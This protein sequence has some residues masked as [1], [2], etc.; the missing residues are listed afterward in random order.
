MLAQH[1]QTDEVIPMLA[2]IGLGLALVS[3]IAGFTPQ[4]G[5]SAQSVA[6]I[7]SL[8]GK[9]QV[10]ENRPGQPVIGVDFGWNKD[11]SG[12]DLAHLKGLP[13]LRSL[14]LEA[15]HI[16]EEGLMHLQEL[17]ALTSLNV[18]ATGATD[19]FMKVVA[20]MTELRSLNISRPKSPT[21]GSCSCADCEDLSPWTL[22][23]CRVSPTLD[24]RI[25][26]ACKTSRSSC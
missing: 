10:D 16:A 23:D 19:A 15:T 25:S 2:A 4:D 7:R 1:P 13:E 8:G 26:R 21:R 11:V 9:I 18:A 20:R 12:G 6:A 22:A 5:D 14:T 24:W 17:T 3:P